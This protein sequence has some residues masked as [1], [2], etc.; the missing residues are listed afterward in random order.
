MSAITTLFEAVTTREFT[1]TVLARFVKAK[2]ISTRRFISA[3]YLFITLLPMTTVGHARTED[4]LEPV[5]IPEF[6]EFLIA[7]NFTLP[8][9]RK[10]Y[11]ADV[12]F[13][14]ADIWLKRFLSETTENYRDITA[15]EYSQILKNQLEE[16]LSRLNWQVVNEPTNDALRLNARLFDVYIFQPETITQKDTIISL[17]GQA[18]IELVF[19][20]PKG[21]TFMKFVD[22]RNTRS[23]NSGLLAN[24]AT[25]Y[26]YFK[27]LMTDWANAATPYLDTVVSLARENP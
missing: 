25:H 11:V 3:V 12:K 13:N 8:V 14:F 24:R 23:N 15:K 7:D 17:V 19:E 9:S 27:I 5:Q 16:A 6:Q 22:H 20:T 21:E 26:Y 10:I 18:G 2:S 1:R 4:K